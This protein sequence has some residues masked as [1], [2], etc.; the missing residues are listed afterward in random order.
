MNAIRYIFGVM[1]G[2]R[3]ALVLGGVLAVVSV[4]AGLGLLA[5][6][7]WLIA[8]SAVAG[9]AFNL[10]AP[11]AGV[12]GFAV[13]RVVGRYLE[14]LI[15]HDATLDAL[16]RLRAWF[17]RCCAHLGPAALSQRASGDVLDRM[18]SDVQ[19]LDGLYLRILIPGLV[20]AVAIPVSLAVIFSVSPAA[21]LAMGVLLATAALI[22][23]RA[24]LSAMRRPSEDAAK[25]TAQL[26][27]TAIEGARGRAELACYG[28]GD[29]FLKR[30]ERESDALIRAEDRMFR[31]EAVQ[32]TLQAAFGLLGLLLA[33]SAAAVFAGGPQAAL[34]AFAALAAFEAAN[35]AAGA[36]E[37]WPRVRVAAERVAEIGLAAE[38]A[39]NRDQSG[40][41]APATGPLALCFDRVTFGYPDAKEPALADVSFQA[42]AQEVFALIG[43]SG[44]GKSTILDLVLGFRRAEI[45]SVLLGDVAVEAWPTASLR[46]E[47]AYVA[48]S[49]EAIAGTIRENLALGDPNADDDAIWRALEMADL[50]RIVRRRQ[51][52][53]DAWI[54]EGGLA[55][56]GGELRRLAVARAA[57]KRSARL[58]LLDEP[59]AG[60]SRPDR[61]RALEALGQVAKGKTT[62]LASHDPDVLTLASHGILLRQGRV[63]GF[64]APLDL[65]AQNAKAA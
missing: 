53:L 35:A 64:G 8:A 11:S 9:A 29:L 61:L 37:R 17:F 20:A 56:S 52:G 1:H 10:F 12:R 55:L 18:L 44:S 50:A 28:G 27:A 42:P 4:L 45:G 15:T 58:L 41:V 47:I 23:P 54:G 32:T 25:A 19:A 39:A 7:G 43:P 24:A 14:R 30:A 59:T 3:R 5:S 60:L 65:W 63:T 38:A 51:D 26:R 2:G 34:T 62:L 33:A 40:D 21:A 57:L 31:I 22:A 46:A 13:L 16:A 6:A 36:F 48:Q 49:G